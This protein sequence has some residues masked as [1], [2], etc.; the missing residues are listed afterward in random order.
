VVASEW[1]KYSVSVAQTGSYTLEARVASVGAGG[2][3]HVEVDGVDTTGPLNVPS[4][5]GWQIWQT[6]TTGRVSLTAGPHVL[7]VVF[8]TNGASGW[9]GNLNYIRWSP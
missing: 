2:I 7:R 9:W 3:F 4:T 1:L 5:G 8:D 6:I